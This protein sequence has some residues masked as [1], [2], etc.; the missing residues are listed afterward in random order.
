MV[1]HSLVPVPGGPGGMATNPSPVRA[2]QPCMCH[3][4]SLMALKVRNWEISTV[5]M[6][7]FRSCLLAKIRTEA[8][9]RACGQRSPARQPSR[10]QPP[11]PVPLECPLAPLLPQ[12]EKPKP[13]WGGHG[14]LSQRSNLSK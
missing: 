9:R 13:K 10:A 1:S 14:G 7:S 6:E 3:G 11:F 2:Q 8:S 5:V 12:Q 4:W